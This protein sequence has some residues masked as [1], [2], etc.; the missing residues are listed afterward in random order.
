MVTLEEGRG[1]LVSLR[2]IHIMINH[3]LVLHLN[4][5]IGPR[6]K[7]VFLVFPPLF[8][9]SLTMNREFKSVWQLVGLHAQ[10]VKISYGK[11]DEGKPG[12]QAYHILNVYL[13]LEKGS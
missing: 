8:H 3:S 1:K 11:N 2:L 10:S 13:Y 9:G 12:M 5:V 4:K 7:A 6:E